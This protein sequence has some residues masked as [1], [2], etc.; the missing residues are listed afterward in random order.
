MECAEDHAHAAAEGAL[1]FHNVPFYGDFEHGLI[2][3][4]AKFWWL[5]SMANGY[6]IVKMRAAVEEELKMVP[7]S[8]ERD[9][10]FIPKR[11]SARNAWLQVV[12]QKMDSRPF[13]GGDRHAGYSTP[14]IGLTT[15]LAGLSSRCP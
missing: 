10:E 12:F 5:L 11:P 3:Y 7:A 1:L 2:N 6:R 8:F 9:I 14:C 15:C 4:N 13:A